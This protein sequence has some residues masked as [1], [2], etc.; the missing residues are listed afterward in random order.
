MIEPKKQIPESG[1]ESK[2]LYKLKELGYKQRSDIKTDRDIEKNIKSHLER[3]EWLK[4][5]KLQNQ[6]LTD[7][8]FQTYFINITKN[9]D[10]YTASKKFR[11]IFV[12]K[13][14]NRENI[15][16]ACF[17]ADIFK[18][19]VFEF[20]NQVKSKSEYTNI[21]DVSI[22]MNGF[23]VC[24]IELKRSGVDIYEAFNQI[25]RYKVENF[26]Q[27]INKFIQIFVIS[28]KET[29]LYFSNNNKKVQKEF[30]FPWSDEHNNRTNELFSFSDAFFVKETLF[31]LI[32]KYIV[33]EET[34]LIK[35]LRPYQYHAVEKIL[36]HINDTKQ[37]NDEIVDLDKR[38]EYLN[39]YVFHATGSGKT[40]TSFKV[41]ELLMQDASI[42]KVIF[43]V[44]RLDLN[45]QTI[46]EFNKFQESEL[47]ETDNT[48]KLASQ[49]KD[50]NN[51]LIVTTI[52]KLNR[53]IDPENSKNTFTKENKELINSN[54][55]FIIDECHRTQF[56]DMHKNIRTTFTKSRLIGFTGTPIV[57][58]N[59][60]D[61]LQVTSD[62]F[63][64]EIHKY[65]LMNAIEDQNVL[66]FKIEY[67]GGPKNKLASHKDIQVESINIEEFFEDKKYID[68]VGEYIYN[69]NDNLTQKRQMKSMLVCSSIQSAIKYYW[70]FRNN[71][72]DLNVATL[73]S[74]VDNDKNIELDKH[75]KHELEKIMDDY[76]K[77]YNKSFS[78][79]SFKEY[80]ASIQSDLT[81]KFGNINLIIVVKM[82]TTGFNCL[83]LNTIYLDR[84]L[85]T[86]E[87]IQTISRVNRVHTKNKTKA[88]IVSFRTFK[89]DVDYAIRLYND[90]E[91]VGF[92]DKGILDEMLTKIN[93]LVD[94]MKLKWP[95][96]QDAHN[97]KGDE[98]KKEF[99]GYMK[100]I[101]KLMNIASSFIEYH[102]SLLNITQ[103]ELSEYKSVHVYLANM[104]KERIFKDS[105]LEDI[106][107]EIEIIS[108]DNI[109]VDHILNLIDEIDLDAGDFQA[110]MDGIIAQIRKSTMK[111]KSE[112]IEKFIRQWEKNR[113][114]PGIPIQ[115]LFANFRLNNVLHKIED[116]ANQN[117]LDLESIKD[118]FVKYQL[119]NK[120]IQTYSEELRRPEALKSL[121]Y[122]DRK[123]MLQK[124][125]EFIVG[126]N[127]EF[128][129]YGLQDD[130]HE[131]VNG[132]KGLKDE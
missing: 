73:F 91:L 8:E 115:E 60:N 20:S 46:K 34:K 36:G 131:G 22:F 78:T 2:L 83:A 132:E 58:G 100:Q 1:I 95:T 92:I 124:I 38:S 55:V 11:D 64:H 97:T 48:R 7:A 118:V 107:F 53:L 101:N 21:S 116:F 10:I 12:V 71:H 57:K 128:E 15:R 54:I 109:D 40:L 23:P 74:F 24:Q 4:N 26:D 69:A 76:N 51:K 88:N 35:I 82:L 106:D 126:L 122:N 87:L 130:W 17:D 113:G 112:L 89:S 108:T 90:K 43:L 41:C 67:I 61:K 59:E 47:D 50:S 127:N 99:I 14:P 27:N 13:R 56:G 77:T 5:N 3:L 30:T 84:K 102:P 114:E 29:T 19:N 45:A 68:I 94:E 25:S 103:D 93:N 129:L 72:P 39:A 9:M 65:M 85:K 121:P 81:T 75:S 110:R 33:M 66:P 104:V 111:S 18:N 44:D 125:K 28:N 105:I 123:I 16:L 63:G 86:H 79:N 62:M 96:S 98:E 52:H 32:T 37:L 119:E 31:K 117:Q 49:L 70:F 80:S 120:D 42:S 6:A